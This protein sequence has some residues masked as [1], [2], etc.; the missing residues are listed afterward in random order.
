M[1]STIR[2]LTEADFDE[3]IPIVANA[4]PGIKIVSA[5]DRQKFKERLI[6]QDKEPTMSFHGLLRD[7]RLLG[8]MKFFDFTMKLLS[9]KALVGGVGLVAVDLLH[10]KERV[11]K[12]LITYYLDHYR[13]Q[14][15]TMTALYPFRP[16]FYKQMGFGYGTKMS[17]YRVQPAALPRG[18][19]REHVT[20]L[21]AADKD[22]LMACYNRYLD[23][24]HGLMEKVELNLQ[25][26][27][28]NLANRVVGYKDG[29]RVLGY[30]VFD[31]KA[32]TPGNFL[33]QEI[34]VH[35][36][37]YENPAV[38]AE[39][40]TFLHTQFDQVERIVFNTQDDDFHF[41][42][43]D[44]R[45]GSGRIIPHVFHES[46]TQ[47][48]GLMYRVIDTPGLFNLLQEHNFGGQSGRFQFNI[49]DS[50]FPA[51]A[52][53]YLVEFDE[54]RPRLLSTGNADAEISLDVA[55][56]SSLLMGCVSFRTLHSY[57]L[58]TLSNPAHLDTLTRLF[59]VEQ[60]PICLTR[61]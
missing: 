61:F 1:T 14:G 29:D 43:S 18:S 2:R 57:N 22:A 26:L 8:G 24:T 46:N 50:F 16:D 23:K 10:K 6:V 20:F 30:L 33:I 44:P 19:S 13:Q 45:N 28:D 58:A 41:L 31:F 25:Y 21:T 56:F 38:M 9:T 3:F 60:K 12:E 7:G 40:F 35:E 17:Q 42:L 59:S 51:N 37:V 5:E 53:R 54:G 48:V 32:D 34:I 52:G 47:G 39:L 11:A 4:Y 27:F 55:E 36:F 49:A 15:A